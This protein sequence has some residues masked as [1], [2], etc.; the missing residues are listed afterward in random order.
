MLCDFFIYLFILWGF[1]VAIIC[2]LDFR[3]FVNDLFVI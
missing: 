1:D 2:L 3:C